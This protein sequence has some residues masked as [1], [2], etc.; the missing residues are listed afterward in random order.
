MGEEELTAKTSVDA[1]NPVRR[2]DLEGH[3]DQQGDDRRKNRPFRLVQLGGHLID[4]ALNSHQ[5]R[6]DVRLLSFKIND[7]FTQASNPFVKFA[8]LFARFL[9]HNY[10]AR[11]FVSLSLRKGERLRA[12]L[13]HI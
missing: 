1:G 7:T 4:A 3:G 12:I 9:V 10:T 11:L 8:H 6:V 5:G 13:Q 2:D